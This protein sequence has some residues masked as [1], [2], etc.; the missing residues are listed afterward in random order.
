MGT[1]ENKQS[2][3]D[4]IQT[5]WEIYLPIRRSFFT[6][7][8]SKEH[9]EAALQ[10]LIDASGYI[11][12]QLDNVDVSIR[13][14]IAHPPEFFPEYSEVPLNELLRSYFVMVRATAESDHVLH[15]LV[16]G[17]TGNINESVPQEQCSRISKEIG[18]SVFCAAIFELV[19]ASNLSRPGVLMPEGGAIFIDGSQ[20]ECI[21]RWMNP[22]DSA[23]EETKHICWPDIREIPLLSVWH[24]LRAVPNLKEGFGGTDLGRSLAA[25]SYLFGD[26]IDG[27][28]PFSHGLWAILGLEAIYGEGSEQITRQLVD[29]TNTFLGKQPT[30]KKTLK[31]MYSFRSRFLH[32]DANLPFSHYRHDGSDGVNRFYI[33]AVPPESM[34]V[35]VLTA[36][37]QKMAEQGRYDLRFRTEVEP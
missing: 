15:Y 31:N 14:D 7:S 10:E 5:K 30:H 9:I 29:R 2:S 3:L 26:S 37:L 8:R 32:G 19:M 28:H 27:G 35:R 23:L 34:A 33:D 1:G 16:D 24:W 17:Q 12:Y 11:T 25:F 6:A 22:I 4:I 18:A 21:P 36:T 13:F 20:H